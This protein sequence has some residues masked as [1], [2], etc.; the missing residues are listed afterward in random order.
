MTEPGKIS[1]R[2]TYDAENQ[3]ISVLYENGV[4]VSYE[5]DKAGNRIAVTCSD[6]SGHVVPVTGS[7]PAGHGAQKA[8]APSVHVAEQLCRNCGTP[9][10]SGK[11][12]CSG[13][14]AMVSSPAM[15]PAHGS[16]AAS[17]APSVCPRC[18]SPVKAGIQYCGDC[19]QRLY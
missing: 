14:G 1:R 3:L 8:T 16:P 17:P 11:K 4:V 5:Y 19:G 6:G 12:F 13:C 10:L 18:K 7:V 2:Y 9:I 15:P